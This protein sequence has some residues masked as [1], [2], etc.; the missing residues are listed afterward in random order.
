MMDSHQVEGQQSCAFGG[1]N[2]LRCE[3]AGEQ[4]IYAWRQPAT[5]PGRKAAC[6]CSYELTVP[7]T[8]CRTRVAELGSIRAALT[9]IAAHGIWLT[10]IAFIARWWLNWPYVSLPSAS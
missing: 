3:I 7:A 9:G 4:E 10:A 2:S 5:S 1:S 8:S 6:W